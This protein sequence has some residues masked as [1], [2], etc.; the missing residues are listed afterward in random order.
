MSD[1]ENVAGLR[2]MATAEVT[3]YVV[4]RLRV[5]LGILLISQQYTPEVRDG[6]YCGN[7]NVSGSSGPP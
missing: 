7:L 4:V 3:R 2:L 6:I 5:T 1:I